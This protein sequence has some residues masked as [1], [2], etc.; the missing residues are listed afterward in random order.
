MGTVQNL[1]AVELVR[2]QR[3]TRTSSVGTSS[4]GGTP[5][6]R[7]TGDQNAQV[8]FDLLIE[9]LISD[10]PEAV[11]IK[12]RNSC[13]VFA[14]ETIA[15]HHGLNGAPELVGK[16]DHDLHPSEQAVEFFA[17][18]QDLIRTGVPIIDHCEWIGGR[19]YSSTKIPIRE[20]NGTGDVIGLIGV[21]RDITVQKQA[22]HLL[23]EQ[24]RVIEMIARDAP[25]DRILANLIGL[26]ATHLPDLEGAFA[27]GTD[28]EACRGIAEPAELGDYGD[29][30]AKRPK[31]HWCAPILNDT[32]QPIGSVTFSSTG[33]RIPSAHEHG[34]LEVIS[35][36]ARMAIERQKT[37]S[38]VRW[39]AY[40]DSLTGLFNRAC[41]NEKLAEAIEAAAASATTIEVA[42]IEL[43]EFKLI[44]DTLSYSTGDQVL[45]VLAQ[46]LLASK[47]PDDSVFRVGGDEFVIVRARAQARPH[48]A[49]SLKAIWSALSE[50]MQVGPHRL[51]VRASAG[52]RGLSEGRRHGPPHPDECRN[53]DAPGQGPRWQSPE[54]LQARIR[55]GGRG[56]AD[57]DQRPRRRSR[58]A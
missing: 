21:G 33:A 5:L 39:L 35:R 2:S 53:R 8:Y 43:D 42:M 19:W 36:I 46:R 48:D 24:A 11:Y 13:F 26:A 56:A 54:A 17:R 31:R 55:Q 38:R 40:N 23:V 29:R 20:W 57:V 52:S 18:E 32:L 10:F 34:I 47:G 49:A 22:E 14:N 44:N 51:S 27:I 4:A 30:D 15:R 3:R 25:L 41:L 12:D 50:P 16:T 9:L 37:Q 7:I 6:E 28:S 58:S 45:Q 1:A